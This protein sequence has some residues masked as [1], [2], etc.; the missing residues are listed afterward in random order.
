MGWLAVPSRRQ[1]QGLE[2]EAWAWGCSSRKMWSWCCPEDAAT[3]SSL[4]WAPS[5]LSRPTIWQAGPVLGGGDTKVNQTPIWP[6]SGSQFGLHR[7][8]K[9]S[10]QYNCT[11]ATVLPASQPLYSASIGLIL[12]LENHQFL[13]ACFA[14]VS[15]I[16]LCLCD[17]CSCDPAGYNVSTQGNSQSRKQAMSLGITVHSRI[18]IFK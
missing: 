11:C 4:W 17:L 14:L 5:S 12:S 9:R 6:S 10:F 16:G 15:G 18:C 2:A 7:W 1:R 8:A 3:S 13:S